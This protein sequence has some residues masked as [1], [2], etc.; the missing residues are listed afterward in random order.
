MTNNFFHDSLQ[1]AN[2]RIA[3]QPTAAFCLLD[4]N[5]QS[6]DLSADLKSLALDALINTGWNRYPDNN[7]ADIEKKVAHYCD[8]QADNIVLAPGSAAIISSL[9]NYFAINGKRIIIN[10]PSYSLFEYHCR[11]YGINYE[12]WML[13]DALSFDVETMPL[14][15]ANSVVIITSPNNPVGNAINPQML[16]QTI[17]TFPDTLF[18]VD[19]VYCEFGHHD[20]TPWI[21]E[22]SNLVV[23]RSFSKAFPMAGLRLGYACTNPAMAATMRKLM[24]PFAIS[25][26]TIAFARK[27]LFQPRFM[28]MAR[29]TVLD[30]ISERE[31]MYR[32]ISVCFHQQLKATPS[33][34][35]FL[36]IHCADDNLFA[37]VMEGLQEAGIRVLNLSNTPMLAQSFRI[38]IGNTAENAFFLETLIKL[39]AAPL[40]MAQ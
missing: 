9:L 16:R 37:L 14:P 7:L 10:Q 13:D 25:P 35:N 19:A 26:L 27:V 4:K 12:P 5:E 17:A 20:F 32:F 1:Q 31:K 8:V 29:K 40:R 39:C 36:H 28:L 24:L 21:H 33:Q 11:T 34:G 30:I 23:L 18:I 2:A 15:D 6:E 3:H 38:S 22:Y